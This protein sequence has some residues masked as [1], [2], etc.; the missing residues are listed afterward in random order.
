MPRAY[1][2]IA[3]ILVTGAPRAGA[4]GTPPAGMR[5]AEGMHHERPG[6]Q[7]T[8]GGQAAFA[9]IQ[10]IVNILDADS[11]TDWSKVNL[12]A[13]RQH[14]IDMDLVT[15]Q[16]RVRQSPAE[17]GVVLDVTGDAAVSPAIRRMLGAHA[18]MLDAMPAYHA[19]AREI[20]GGM[21]MTVTSRN[22]GDAR[23]VA[24]VRGLG[25]IGLMTEG[26]HHT[27]HHLM[28]ARGMGAHAH[29]MK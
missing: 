16:A 13:L 29:D 28:I 10:E 15:M 6:A 7:P 20:P 18:P 8:R 17:G 11:T 19:T 9:A 25:F 12:E 22:T 4:Q 26:A 24:R 1:A 23:A 21:R 14:L 27:P 5:H 2:L 3:L